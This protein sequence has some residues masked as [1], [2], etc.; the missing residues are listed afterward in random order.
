MWLKKA[1]SP[2][3]DF[4]VALRTL[5]KTQVDAPPERMF[6]Y[7]NIG[8]DV[9]GAMIEAAS[10]QPF[11]QR[12]QEAIFAPLGMQGAQFS[13][14]VP[15]DV[16][17]ARAHFRSEARDEPALRDVPAGAMSASV[18]DL[19]YFLMMQFSGGRNREGVAVLPAAQQAAMLK[20]QY[21]GLLLNG[22]MRTGLGW[23][24][25]S[26]DNVRGGGTVAYHG[27]ATR[28]FRSQMTMLPEQ[29]LGVVVLSNDAAAGE[30]VRGVAKRALALLLEARSGIRQTPPEPG[31][32]PSAQAW[33]SDQWQSVRAAC[34]GDY[35]TPLGLASVK[36]KGQG[37]SARV[38]D[39]Q[40][41]AREGEAGR[42]GVRYRLAATFPIKHGFQSEIGFE[43][44][45]VDGRHVL[46]AVLDGERVLVGERLS[47]PSLPTDISRWTGHYKPRLLE[48]EVPFVTDKGVRVFEG[49]GRLLAE[50]QIHSDFGGEKIRVLLQPI[51][52]TM[53]RVVGPL[54]DTGPVMH[55]ES[56][57]DEVPRFR[58]SGWT[59]DRVA[60]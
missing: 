14:A 44:T 35:M 58:F 15:T 1:P 48:G 43:C 13:A 54:S 37:L 59:F 11:E 22:D 46:F 32:V 8:I 57:K 36:P 5:A 10:G 16:T 4:R 33:T 27:G 7:S 23:R 19:A 21:P 50:Y 40:F 53:V 26:G 45:Q 17:I 60:E 34:A 51:S 38:G 6:S 41:E 28:Y 24:L 31:F 30:I 29:K 2:R 42:I 39:R 12:V 55:L 56:E 18:T 20:R 49:D 3:Q 52:E 47:E 25:S 9:V